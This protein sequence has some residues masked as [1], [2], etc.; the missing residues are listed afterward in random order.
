MLRAA[1]RV[2]I[3][4]SAARRDSS[5]DQAVPRMACDIGGAR[6]MAALDQ[7]FVIG[8]S[9]ATPSSETCWLHV[10]PSQ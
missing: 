7:G 6:V 4:P 2:A 5:H 3:A 10:Y 1:R 9:P 8:S